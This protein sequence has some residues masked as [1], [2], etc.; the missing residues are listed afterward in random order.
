MSGV[1]GFC[2][3]IPQQKPHILV[4]FGQNINFKQRTELTD[5]RRA[6]NKSHENQGFHLDAGQF[7]G[8]LLC[9]SAVKLSCRGNDGADENRT[10]GLALLTAVIAK[11]VGYGQSDCSYYCVH[12]FR[13]FKLEIQQAWYFHIQIHVLARALK[14]RIILKSLNEVCKQTTI[15]LETS[16]DGQTSQMPS[17]VG[18]ENSDLETSDLRPRK[19]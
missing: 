14:T 10:L 9:T 5:R 19:L 12:R 11:N 7:V 3:Y 4:S 13:L 2:E 18:L 6:E 15:C 8:A 1:R 16:L 17:T